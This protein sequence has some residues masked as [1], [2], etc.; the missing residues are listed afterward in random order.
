MKR[1]EYKEFAERPLI[2]PAGVEQFKQWVLDTLNAYG[3]KGWRIHSYNVPLQGNSFTG[4]LLIFAE[5]ELP[6]MAAVEAP[7]P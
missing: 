2:Q 1:Y 5:R 3:Q 7:G 4:D 6:P